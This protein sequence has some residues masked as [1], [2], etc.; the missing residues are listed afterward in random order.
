MPEQVREEPPPLLH[1]SSTSSFDLVCSTCTLCPV[2]DLLPPSPTSTSVIASA[3]TPSVTPYPLLVLLL[4]LSPSA[5]A[6]AGTLP[7]TCSSSLCPNDPPAPSPHHGPSQG[8]CIRFPGLFEV[9]RSPLFKTRSPFFKTRMQ[10]FCIGKCPL[11][12]SSN[13]AACAHVVLSRAS[14]INLCSCH[15]AHGCPL[16]RSSRYAGTIRRCGTRLLA[17]L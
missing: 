13:A 15:R 11:L 8:G 2:L 9:T 17:L 5:H 12:S 4:L 16:E 7:A 3:F 10:G 1:R 6:S 14:L